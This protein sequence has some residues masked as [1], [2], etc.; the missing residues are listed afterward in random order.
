M[1]VKYVG[2]VEKL[3]NCYQIHNYRIFYRSCVCSLQTL[4]WNEHITT[5]N[6]AFALWATT[7]L[8][9]T[10]SMQDK[11]REFSISTFTWYQWGL[12]YISFSLSLWFSCN[13]SHS[14]YSW[15]NTLEYNIFKD[16]AK[17]RRG[18]GQGKIK[19]LKNILSKKYFGNFFVVQNFDRATFSQIFYLYPYLVPVGGHPLDYLS[20]WV[21]VG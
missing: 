12:D 19:K 16:I 11:D 1:N 2:Y 20:N 5:Q 21:R 6:Y 7:S 3:V 9:L 8:N 17:K 4:H 18:G 14:S 13:Y 15:Q 10:R